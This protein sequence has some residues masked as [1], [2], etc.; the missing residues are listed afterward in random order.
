MVSADA[1]SVGLVGVLIVV[2]MSADRF[3]MINIVIKEQ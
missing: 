3:H 1:T 2:T